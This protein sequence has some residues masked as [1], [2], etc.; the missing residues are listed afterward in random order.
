MTETK[1]R[2]CPY[3][4][5]DNMTYITILSDIVMGA[6]W[7]GN[8]GAINSNS[9]GKW[10]LLIPDKARDTIPVEK[11][12]DETVPSAY[13]IQQYIKS[14]VRDEVKKIFVGFSAEASAEKHYSGDAK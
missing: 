3:C 14:V 1:S 7:C 8:C 10:T 13:V 9:S 5:S 11:K 6:Y 4:R 12:E 2:V